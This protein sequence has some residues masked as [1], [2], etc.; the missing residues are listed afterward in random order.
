MQST[1]YGAQVSVTFFTKKFI[2]T[3]KGPQ[4]K[5]WPLRYKTVQTD[6]NYEI[7]HY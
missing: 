1:L 4:H 2:K 3:G 5:I 6:T 7:F